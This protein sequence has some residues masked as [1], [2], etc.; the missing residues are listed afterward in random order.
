MGSSVKLILEQL[1][2]QVKFRQAKFRVHADLYQKI[3]QN[4]NEMTPET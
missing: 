2:Q 3:L 1:I 4:P